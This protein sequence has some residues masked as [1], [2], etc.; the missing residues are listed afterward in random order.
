MEEIFREV[1]AENYQEFRKNP[2]IKVIWKKEI[3][4]LDRFEKELTPFKEWNKEK[5]E[6]VVR[7]IN[8]AYSTRL[9]NVEIDKLSS[10]ICRPSFREEKSVAIL[11]RVTQRD[12][13]SFASKFCYHCWPT[14]C[15]IF[16]S[17]NESVLIKKG[18]LKEKLKK[19][20]DG[21]RNYQTFRV[22]YSEFFKKCNPQ[23][24][25]EKYEPFLVDKYIQCIGK[26]I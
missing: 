1:T 19:E 18:Y 7:E 6:K 12:L 5:V 9:S 3:D 13:L 26:Y 22:A 4:L 15:P 25:K 24:S 2:L 8:A 23:E 20:S 10:F 17:V 14:E 11:Q 21:Y 16:D